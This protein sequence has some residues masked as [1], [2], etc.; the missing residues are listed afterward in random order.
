MEIIF[1]DDASTDD[2]KTWR[3]LETIEK[4][5]PE[6]VAIIHLEENSH[7]GGAR[8]VGLQYVAGEYV[9]FLDADD[10]LKAETCFEL[11]NIAKEKAADIVQFKHY[12][13]ADDEGIRGIPENKE[14]KG[15][16]EIFDLSDNNNELRKKLLSRQLS[17]C[18]CTNKLYSVEL[19]DKAGA[20]YAEKAIYE[21]PEFV[22]PM[23][24]YAERMVMV[25]KAYYEYHWHK[26][27]T[28]TGLLGK[29]LMDHP[30]VQ[31]ELM[32]ILLESKEIYDEYKEEIDYYFFLS[33]YVETLLFAR[34]YKRD[35]SMEE[36]ENLQ[37]II[38][39]ITPSINH[40]EYIIENKNFEWIVQ[41]VFVECTS[42]EQIAEIE[43]GITERIF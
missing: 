32:T 34:A 38:K 37:E 39:K 25:D 35:I 1:V 41:T 4:E 6:S 30:K 23:F 36:M 8:N 7:Q 12:H 27:S 11:Y 42:E 33:F 26:D 19:I 31:L 14:L 13:I 29:R 21:E 24:L 5:A 43:K 40:N 9:L 22:Y 18:S 15:S 10:T 3:A 2:G 28:M 20:R 17:N 16:L